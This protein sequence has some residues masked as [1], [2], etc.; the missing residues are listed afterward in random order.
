[1]TPSIRF[2]EI[3]PDGHGQSVLVNPSNIRAMYIDAPTGRTVIELTDGIRYMTT[4]KRFEIKNR[5]ERLNKD[6][7]DT[8]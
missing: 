5:V 4:E 3:Y 8:P 6:D 7:E 2:L 1:M